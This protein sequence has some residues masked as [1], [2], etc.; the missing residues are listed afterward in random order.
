MDVF[1]FGEKYLVHLGDKDGDHDEATILESGEWLDLRRKEQECKKKLEQT[2]ASPNLSTESVETPPSKASLV[3]IGDGNNDPYVFRSPT[4]SPELPHHF[5]APP[6]PNEEVEPEPE[7]ECVGKD[8]SPV[9]KTQPAF[10]SNNDLAEILKQ[11]EINNARLSQLERTLIKQQ[12]TIEK[13][14]AF[15]SRHLQSQESGKTQRVSTAHRSLI[16]AVENESDVPSPLPSHSSCLPDMQLTPTTSQISSLEQRNTF[17]PA[18][19]FTI[20]TPPMR[21]TLTVPYSL[22]SDIPEQFLISENDLSRAIYSSKGPGN[23]ACH[24]MPILFP[25]L[26]TSDNLRTMYTFYSGGKLVEYLYHVYWKNKLKMDNY[27]VLEIIGEGSFGK[28][29]K[30]RKKF[31]SQVV[32]L[33]FIPKVGKPEKEL[34]NL[35]REIEIMRNLHHENIIEMLDS[36]ETDKEVVVVTDYAEG[37]LFQIL[38]DDGSLPEEQVQVIA[39]Q[40]VSALYY[41]HSHRILHRDMKPQNILLGKGGIIKLCDFGFARAMSFNTLVLTSIKGTPLYMS[42]ELVEEKPYDHTADLWALGC[43]LYELFTGTPPFYTNSIFQLVSLIIKDPVKWP[44]NMSSVFKDFLQGLLTKNPRSRLAWPDLLMHPFVG[45]GVSVKDEDT[46]LLSPFTQPLTASMVMRKEKQAQEKAHPPGTSKIL[47]KARKKA[48]EE[49][50][51]KGKEPPAPNGEKISSSKEAWGPSKKGPE[52]EKIEKEKEPTPPPQELE[53]PHSE[54][55]QDTGL[56]EDKEPEIENISPTPRPDRISKDYEKEYPKKDK[57]KEKTKTIENV[58]L[59]GEEV[60]SDDEWEG[61]IDATDQEGDPEQAIQMLKDSKFHTRLNTRIQNSSTQVLDGMLEG[62]AKLKSVLRIITN[63]ITLKCD[64]KWILTFV[65]ALS[66]PQQPLKMISNILNKPTVRQQPWCQQILIDLVI[67]VN[68]YFAS[69]VS[70]NDDIDKEVGQMY[71]NAM[72]EYMSLVPKLLNVSSDEDLRLREQVILCSMYTCE[73]ME[74][75]KLKI[76]N[77]YFSHMAAK[78]T[79]AID[80]I[81]ACCKLEEARLKKLIEWDILEEL[82]DGNEDM[83]GER[84]DML[85]SLG[86]TTVAAMVNLPLTADDAVDGRRKIGHY[87]GDKMAC[88]GNEKQTDEFFMLLRHPLFCTNVLKIMYA[89]CQVSTTLCSYISNQVQHMDSLMGILMGKVEIQDMEVNSVIEMILHIYSTIV[90][91]LQTMPTAITD[92]ASVM[93]S[94][95]LESTIASHTAAAALVFSQMIYC[96]LT[97]EVQPEEMLQA[98]LAVFT[99]LQQ[100]CVRCPFD[101]GVLDGLLLLLCEMLAQTEGPVA[102]MYIETG[103]WGTLWHRVAQALQV[104]NLET[105]TPIHD[106]DQDGENVVGF[107]P[108]DWTLVS[109]QGLMAV[110]QMAV[111]VF[112]K[113]TNQCIPNLAVPDSIILLTVLYFKGNLS[114]VYN[115]FHCDGPQLTADMILEVTQLCC[116][117]F[118]VDIA[119]ELLHQVQQCL[120]NASLLPRLIFCC[121]K[122]LKNEQ[123]EIPINL[124]LRLVLGSQQF[125]KQFCKCVKEQKTVSLLSQCTQSTS[126]T[127]VSDVVSICSHLV[128]MSPQHAPF[129]KSVFHGSK[130]DYDPLLKLIKHNSATVRSRA[131][132]LVGNL[133]KHNSH[134]YG[135][136]KQREKL[137]NG[138]IAGLKDEDPNVRKGSSYAI[139]NAAYH[140][141]DL[142]VKLKPCIPLLVELLRD[143]VSK[144]KANAASACGNLGAHS[145]VLCLELKKQKIIP[146]LLDLA[147]HDQNQGVQVNAILAL[148]TLSQQDELKKEMMNQKAVDKLNAISVATTPRPLSRS[149]KTQSLLINSFHS[150]NGSSSVVYSHCSKLVRMLQGKG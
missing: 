109:P 3:D 13:L 37:E 58:K 6:S 98:C 39:C 136:L 113:E 75:D 5:T 42:P 10:S 64:L 74:R 114:S 78:E 40:L 120:F 115:G 49:E 72:T 139:G 28:V 23:F 118:A 26:F 57:N 22:F 70:W 82:T 135:V 86:V 141:G 53:R 112:T 133:M 55:W 16:D 33:K 50:K 97:V 119:E 124:M 63:L 103:I 145:N 149:S 61:L 46:K 2:T 47:A 69:E 77:Q 138:L 122:Y 59:D 143:P 17:S 25:E 105:D 4:P 84:M 95:F 137:L 11:V 142:Y 52:K 34:R 65:K 9:Q 148:R 67:T 83:A 81:L 20:S 140:N 66:I 38:E 147:C 93:I 126:S 51:K 117:P 150:N 87:L 73:A 127:V 107:N 35:R 54:E 62:A 24:I 132:S 30:G 110:L 71:L 44:K 90:I 144:T 21:Q 108:P 106:I 101:Y 116:F 76:G 43:I 56:S 85:I 8:K 131:C 88:K 80:A 32:A 41:L 128:R 94:I 12:E 123:L 27:H 111:T 48:M 19:G 79:D 45:D 91:Q 36:F 31:S 125:L 7:S 100:I 129:V 102:Q 134:M 96:G 1:S 92:A 68:A 14:F 99:D 130:G 121:T 89:C 18:F 15:V 146:R 60:C 104:I 29:Y